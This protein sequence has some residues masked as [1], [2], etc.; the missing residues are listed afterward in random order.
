MKIKSVI[1]VLS[2]SHICSLVGKVKVKFQI[3]CFE[4]VLLEN[5]KKLHNMYYKEI[6]L[7]YKEIYYAKNV[8]FTTYL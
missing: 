1:L 7:Y 6:I 3:I 2:L 8:D 5:S 4:K